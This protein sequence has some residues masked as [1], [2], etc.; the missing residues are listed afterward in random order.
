MSHSTKESKL[1]WGVRSFLK[2][3]LGLS[4]SR[5]PTPSQLL[6]PPSRGTSS[7]YVGSSEASKSASVISLAKS[8]IDVPSSGGGATNSPKASGDRR[9]RVNIVPPDIATGA[10]EQPFGPD[11]LA[12]STPV[13]DL[14]NTITI[15][16]DPDLERQNTLWAG[17]G[18]SLEMLKDGPSMIPSFISPIET[19]LSCL[20]GLKTI[21]RSR[22][23]YEDPTKELTALSESLRHHEGGLS[24]VPISDA[25]LNLIVSID[26]EARAIKAKL[27]GRAVGNTGEVNKAEEELI[28]HY[29]GMPSLFRLLKINASMSAK[30]IP[31]ESVVHTRLDRLN[32]VKEATYDS[33]LPTE[34]G[35]Q[36]CAKGTRV[37]VLTGLN[38]WLSDS[39]SPSVYWIDGMA[40][41]GKTTIAYTFC[42]QMR[43]RKFLAASFFCA[44]ESTE[45]RDMSRIL[46]TI[47]HQVAQYSIPFRAAL[48]DV[49]GRNPEAGSRNVP[50]QFD[51][52]LVEPFQQI[53]DTMPG[54]MVV[55][56][57]A[58]D[59]CAN[60]TEVFLEL[61]LRHAPHMPLKFI[62]TSR[63]QTEIYIKMSLNGQF[64]TAIHLHDIEQSVVQADIK[65]YLTQQLEFMSPSEVEIDQL[66]ERAGML[67]MY[68]A[69]LVR[70]AQSNQD[71]ADSR[72]RLKA[73]IDM[74]PEEQDK[75]VGPLYIKVVDNALNDEDLEEDEIEDIR[76][77][78][79]TVL[80]AQEPI[81]IET[82][83]MLAGIENLRRVENALHPLRDVLRYSEKTGLVSTLDSTF[84]K[85]MF[86]KERSKEH[87]CD[88][89]K[90]SQLLA[91]GCFLGMKGRLQFNICQLESS[92]LFD[93]KVDNLQSRI[94]DRISPSLA[95]AC[96]YWANHLSLVANI[97]GVLMILG[98]FLTTQLLLWM[99]VLNLRR[100]L[101][102]GITALLKAKQRLGG[103]SSSPELM[104]LLEE[105]HAFIRDFAASQVSRSTPHIYI[106]SLQLSPKSNILYQIYS[107]SV[108]SLLGVHE[109]V[110]ERRGMPAV[111]H[112]SWEI[113][114]GVLSIA[115]SP[116]GTRVAVG[117]E[118]GTIS[119]CDSRNGSVLAGPLTGHTSWV[120]CVVFSPDGT[121]LLSS[122]SD[123]TI[124]MWNALDGNPT[125]APFEGHT[126]PVRSVAFSSDGN[127]VVS[128]SWDDTIRIW[129]ATNGQSITEPLEGHEHGVN[130]VAFQPHSM[131][132]ASGGNDH[133]VR[134]W[135][136]ANDTLSTTK[137]L[138]GH[139]NSIMS[140][141]FTPDGARLVSGAVDS[142]ICVWNVSD[143]T[144]TSR[145]LQDCVHHIYS[146]AVSPDG[147]CVASGSADCTIRVWNIDTGKLLA[148]PIMGHS[149]G[150]RAIT[151]SPD[152]SRVLSGSHDGSVRT[153]HLPAGPNSSNSGSSSQTQTCGGVWP[154]GRAN[155]THTQPGA[156]N[157]RDF[158]VLTPQLHISQQGNQDTL[159][160][161]GQVPATVTPFA[162]LLD[163][164]DRAYLHEDS[165]TAHN[166]PSSFESGH[167]LAHLPEGWTWRSDGWLVNSSSQLLVWVAPLS[168][169]CHIFDHTARNSVL[170]SLLSRDGQFIGNRWPGGDKLL[171][172]S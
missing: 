104:A 88:A 94:K 129:D 4:R 54:R 42:E 70:Y 7:L 171:G 128:G 159:P 122:S 74:T 23:E 3:K 107:K 64:W 61:L 113:D 154:Q 34:I 71:S 126:H 170:L 37:A 68:A 91:Q 109:T 151:F 59:E 40:G 148:G 156:F 52:L 9:V 155:R 119:I 169:S 100:E 124:R 157:L 1:N 73:L 75:L 29:R 98:E 143:G 60:R 145:F 172:G 134:L 163:G 35:R 51:Q 31:N 72:E 80:L 153:W 142:T 53:K 28:R 10:T 102:I 161:H 27:E 20:D 57:D 138:E 132:V 43:D 79:N 93:E 110:T 18:T 6:L 149:R 36:G 69:N 8:S 89:A 158:G 62:V 11:E 16:N 48:C 38:E 66:V 85:I 121:R 41:T 39:A 56:I 117:C 87:F 135:D 164:S 167:G 136:M 152:G 13:Q 146:I 26:D 127:R 168:G 162:W 147:S 116:D 123:R 131:L 114:S 103:I 140:V 139:T 19:L 160:I 112:Q 92:F 2:D 65:L 115:Y 95:Y 14:P 15:D 44:R 84:P 120:R 55:V 76:V 24:S 77:V 78:L 108:K 17:L 45:C 105:A 101:D 106:S 99:E 22:A 150:V 25:F 49:L 137:V 81:S 33:G 32:P 63:P 46:P 83:G 5:S 50:K 58:L 166:K 141:A 96:R 67:F 130:C 90:H 47:A 133:T 97:D 111:D 30:Q 12:T 82:I 125:P 118:N 144:L 86:S 165:S 21:G